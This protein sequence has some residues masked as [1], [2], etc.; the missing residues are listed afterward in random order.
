MW[1]SVATKSRFAVEIPVFVVKI[2]ERKR[3]SEQD[4]G[5]TLE[6][7]LLLSK[8]WICKKKK[9]DDFAFIAR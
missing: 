7:T 5:R 2:S 3:I 6:L 8:N 1:T 4:G 9:R